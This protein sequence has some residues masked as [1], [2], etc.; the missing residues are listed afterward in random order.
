[1]HTHQPNLRAPV[2]QRPQIGDQ[3]V[4][5][6]HRSTDVPLAWLAARDSPRIHECGEPVYARASKLAMRL[7][8]SRGADR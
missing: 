2:V 4:D 6:P 8:N 7:G 3:H 5:F 1:M